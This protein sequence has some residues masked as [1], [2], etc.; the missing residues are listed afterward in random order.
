LD[1]A[2]LQL[3]A[4]LGRGG[5]KLV[6]D[7]L[8]DAIPSCTV[9][10]AAPDGKVLRVSEFAANIF[11]HPREV[12]EGL[13]LASLIDRVQPRD[14]Q[15]RLL[16][17]EELPLMRALA[18]ETIHGFEGKLTSGYGSVA[19]IA[20]SA[21]PIRNRRGEIIGAVSTVTDMTTFKELIAHLLARRA[22]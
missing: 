11:G 2:P 21:A 22:P 12:L 10:I 8:M 18:G 3:Y 4:D 17:A 16:A 19:L 7:A 20:S 9:V 14:A 13:T 15:G 5:A 6:L 1:D